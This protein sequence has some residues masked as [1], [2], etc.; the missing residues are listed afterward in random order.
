[1]E[2]NIAYPKSVSGFENKKRGRDFCAPALLCRCLCEE[3]FY[4]TQLLESASPEP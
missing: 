3:E 2:N 4:A 1:L